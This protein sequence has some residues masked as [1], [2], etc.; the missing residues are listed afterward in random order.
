MFIDSVKLKLA[1]GAGGN[2]IVAWRREKCIP[3]GGP[4]G[5]NGGKGGN[6][7]IKS[8]PDVYSLEAYR[9]RRHLSAQNGRLG[10]VNR[11]AGRSGT[12]LTLKVPLGT[13]IKDTETNE[14]LFD[15]G[16][17]PTQWMICA[18]G[19][20]GLGNA[21]FKSARNQAPNK[22]TP[23]LEGEMRSV[24][25]ELKLIADIGLIGM[26]NAGKSTFM[27]AVT[28]TK[29]NIGAY[30]FTTLF[31]NLSF[32]QC[33]DYR[34]LLIAD[35]PGIIQGAHNNKGLGHAF[36]RHIERTN[37][38]LFVIDISGIEGRNPLDDFFM[39]RSELES[40]DP[41]L[42]KKPFLV[43]LNKIDT[44]EAK[45]HLS[46]FKE[47]YPYPKETLFTIS[48]KEKQGLTPLITALQN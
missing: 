20:G 30:P 14:V 10:G 6:V 28:H 33:E 34:R 47:A 41:A 3:K 1:A 36:L 26:P 29:V 16:S 39:L 32:I 5:G 7:L 40:Y 21:C 8:S 44:E 15:F 27:E 12:N 23:G 9:N 48:T 43:A 42:L 35:I 31:P 38:L 25:F 24:E 19:R 45:Q 22:S 4:Y 11:R 2:G 37:T 18:G 17:T 46:T 13:L